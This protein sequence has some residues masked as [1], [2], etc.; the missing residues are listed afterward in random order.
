VGLFEIFPDSIGALVSVLGVLLGHLVDDGA[1]DRRDFE[2][3]GHSEEMIEWRD[4]DGDVSVND[5]RSGAKV[6]E[7]SE[8]DEKLEEGHAH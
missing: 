6:T 8:A 4:V 2:A 7:G 3:G 5:G 1:D